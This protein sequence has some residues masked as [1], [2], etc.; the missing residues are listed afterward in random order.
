MLTKRFGILGAIAIL[1]AFAQ[2]SSLQPKTDITQLTA[3]RYNGPIK[4]K[5]AHGDSSVTSTNWSGYAVTGTGFTNAVGSWIVPALTCKSGTEYAVFWVGIDGYN[6]GTVEQAGTEG[7][8]SGTSAIYSAWYEFY[9]ATP[10]L[11][12]S[13]ITVKPGDVM[14]S[15][16]LY[17]TATSEFTVEIKNVTT[18][19]SYSTAST[20]SG[21][22]RSSAEFIAEAPS[23]F[24]VLPLADYGTVLF[25]KDS[26][27]LPGCTAEDTATHAVIGAFPAADI[28]AIT[29]EKNNVV[30]SIPSS[31]S[32]DGS[33]FSVT[34]AAQ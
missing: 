7:V 1:P 18:G 24:E 21:A 13:S 16:I 2:V 25:G 31:L 9:P 3:P 33:S 29:M 14:E 12:I 10:I 17:D 30:E 22:E 20:V 34:W 4:G 23:S 19:K 5:L 32:S 6:D 8:C 26:T 11:T 27:S 15:A 28:F